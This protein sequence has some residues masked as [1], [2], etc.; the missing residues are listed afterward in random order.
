MFF[1]FLGTSAASVWFVFRDQRFDY[2]ILFLGVLGVDLV[3]ALF[4]SAR[5]LHS[6]TA[7]VAV[8][9]VVVLVTQ[10][11][12]PSRQRWLALPIGMFLHLVFDGA[13]SAQRIFWWPAREVV[14]NVFTSEPVGWFA[15]FDSAR[16]PSVERGAFN[17]VLESA[18]LLLLA[19]LWR[20]HGLSQR[21]ARRRFVRTGRLTG[22]GEVG[23][24]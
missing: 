5:V 8:L 22:M 21:E 18:G 11:G 23:R 24:C 20:V 16:L 14:Y 1:W 9:L 7:S 12:G 10:R 2:R 6:V 17:V 3:D 19:W 13:F 15:A 4:R